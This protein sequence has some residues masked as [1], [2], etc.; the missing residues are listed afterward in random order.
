MFSLYFLIMVTGNFSK[1]KYDKSFDIQLYA[2]FMSAII[3]PSTALKPDEEFLNEEFGISGTTLQ[4]VSLA[5]V[6]A[7]ES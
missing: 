1:K 4:F 7:A 2:F 6:L 5:G 3:F